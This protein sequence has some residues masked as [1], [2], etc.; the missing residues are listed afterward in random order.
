[1]PDAPSKPKHKRRWFQ[2]SLLKL[3]LLVTGLA[4]WFGWLAN[5]AR[6]QR[7]AVAWVEEMG[8]SV[9]Y[10]YETDEDGEFIDDVEPPGPK[11]LR[12]IL[13]IDFL[14]DVVYVDLYDTPVSDVTPLAGLTNLVW[15]QLNETPVSEEE[16]TKL[17]Q[18]LPNCIIPD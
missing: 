10:D 7:E 17:R 2:F 6:E 8:G 18:A 4:L 5:Q 16:I 9:Q 11:W 12:D 13:G 3:L 15:L 1:M 14:D